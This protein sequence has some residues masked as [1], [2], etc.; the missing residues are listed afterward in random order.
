MSF[1]GIA[2]L[3]Y[4][5]GPNMSARL[6]SLRCLWSGV[7]FMAWAAAIALQAA[8]PSPQPGQTIEFSAPKSDAA[9]TNLD[10]LDEKLHGEREIGAGSSQEQFGILSGS[11]LHGGLPPPL[12]S[13]PVVVR[14]HGSD[15][16]GLDAGAGFRTPEET[17][18]D[19]LIKQ[20]LGVPASQQNDPRNGSMQPPASSLQSFYEQMLSGRSD[21][22]NGV[23]K[24]GFSGSRKTD[25]DGKRS[26]DPDDA[27]APGG[28]FD[29]LTTKDIL[30]SD[31]NSRLSISDSRPN[32]DSDF[33][34]LGNNR[35]ADIGSLLE[36]RREQE[37]VKR[38]LED[39]RAILGY[40]STPA[41][42]DPGSAL[43]STRPNLL[44]V[45]R[46]AAPAPNRYNPF[47]LTPGALGSTQPLPPGAP[48]APVPSSLTPV[49]YTPP[50]PRVPT[51]D[52]SVPR[53]VF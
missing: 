29:A 39:Y 46:P 53:R 11:S 16:F 23:K 41:L 45:S 21:A 38:Q 17:F 24:P 1:D 22:A 8:D 19:V 26:S 3:S 25:Q 20:F 49:P 31:L 6:S 5:D 9:V 43:S 44:S 18:R 33:F 42:A 40:S 2:V 13:S 7:A 4:N 48:L 34:G 36:A 14:R 32:S 12:P 37:D 30:R 10:Q 28:N 51:S 50:P 27:K 15:E 47:A 35:K 52:F